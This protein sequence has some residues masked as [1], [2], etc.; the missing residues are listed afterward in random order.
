MSGPL[1]DIEIH[2]RVKDVPIAEAN[3]AIRTAIDKMFLGAVPTV[4]TPHAKL[5]IKSTVKQKAG[6]INGAHHHWIKNRA[7]L[8]TVLEGFKLKYPSKTITDAQLTEIWHRYHEGDINP[9][10]TATFDKSRTITGVHHK[11]IK[12]RPSLQYVLENFSTRFPER[13]TNPG[14]L[15]EIWHLYHKS[16]INDNPVRENKKAVKTPGPHLFGPHIK[17]IMNRGS[18]KEVIDQFNQR[19]PGLNAPSEKL[20]EIW[21]RYHKGDTNPHAKEAKP[22]K[23]KLP[24]KVEK[25]VDMRISMGTA[26]TEVTN[27]PTPVPKKEPER[28]FVPPEATQAELT[29]KLSEVNGDNFNVIKVGDTV[30]RTGRNGAAYGPGTVEKIVPPDGDL[31]IKFRTHRTTIPADLVEKVKA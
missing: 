7:N 28:I 3:S 27:T 16:D 24:V 20:T 6:V 14:Q 12:N 10:K 18:L 8:Q 31:Q 21:H 29:K 2:V 25:P 9:D 1:I 4:N 26:A 23:T 13:E 15:A 5:E 30:K 22:V 11:W 19:Y 17:W